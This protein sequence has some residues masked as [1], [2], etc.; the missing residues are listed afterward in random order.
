[1]GAQT[2]FRILLHSGVLSVSTR[3]QTFTCK[4]FKK[5]VEFPAHSVLSQTNLGGSAE[6]RSD[7]LAD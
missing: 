2:I 7:I 1:M 3:I 4:S 6:A 5:S